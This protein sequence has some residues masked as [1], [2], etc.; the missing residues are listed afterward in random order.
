MVEAPFHPDCVSN[1]SCAEPGVD[2]SLFCSNTTES[3]L[4]TYD[5]A[6]QDKN[7]NTMMVMNATFRLLKA[8]LE[9]HSRKMELYVS[10]SV[11]FLWTMFGTNMHVEPLINEL[12]RDN[13]QIVNM[14]NESE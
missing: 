13:Q 2:G 6:S 4:T 12:I 14:C 9:G 7:R 8:C 11:P 3:A 10:K 5:S 1:T